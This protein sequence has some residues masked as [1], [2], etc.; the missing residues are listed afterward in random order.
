MGHRIWEQARNII[1]ILRILNIYY[2]LNIVSS[3]VGFEF[4]EQSLLIPLDIILQATVGIVENPR[5]FMSC[6]WHSIYFLMPTLPF[7]G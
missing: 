7:S 2:C 3:L 6:V 1:I 4:D 5:G